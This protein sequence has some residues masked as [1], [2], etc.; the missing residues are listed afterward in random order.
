MGGR[1]M[2]VAASLG[3]A[4]GL[5]ARHT[6][7]TLAEAGRQSSPAVPRT[8]DDQAIAELA[9]RLKDKNVI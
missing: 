4:L 6:A 7:S 3:V 9:N 8:W 1:L 2:I 5:P